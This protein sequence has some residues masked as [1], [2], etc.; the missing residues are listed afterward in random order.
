VNKFE[1]FDTRSTNCCHSVP[2]LY[3]KG[4]KAVRHTSGVSVEFMP[5]YLPLT[6]PH[7]NILWPPRSIASAD[8]P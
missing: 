3:P 5:R 6:V 1:H 7:R 8:L 4:G 2:W